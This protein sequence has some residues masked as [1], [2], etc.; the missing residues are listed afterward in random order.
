MPEF[1][2][3]GYKCYLNKLNARN[4]CVVNTPQGKN[5]TTWSE[6]TYI[7]SLYCKNSCG[8]G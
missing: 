4:N 7:A 3:N 2:G 6:G 8:N 5:V 1:Q